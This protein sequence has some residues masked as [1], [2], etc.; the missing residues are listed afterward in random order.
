MTII[1]IPLTISEVGP[2]PQNFGGVNKKMLINAKGTN[3]TII[4][5]RLLPNLLLVRSDS[6]PN[7]GS[8]I[9]SQIANTI[10]EIHKIVP[11]TSATSK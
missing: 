7:I 3:D 11:P 10:N 4:Q 1:Y 8:L 6:G 9:E 5:K 2:M